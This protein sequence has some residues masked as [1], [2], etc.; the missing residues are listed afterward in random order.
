MKVCI[1]GTTRGIG[2][3]LAEHFKNKGCEV[4][5]LNRGDLKV[6]PGVG[7]DLYINNAYANGCQIDIFNQLYS[8]VAKMV[9]IG[10]IA[11]DYPDPDMPAYSQHKKELKER[12]LEIANSS[13]N[14]ADILLL[15]LTGES[16]NDSNLII[17][18]IEFWLANPKITC[19]SFVPGKPN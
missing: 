17:R 3:S 1:T 2:K 7:C 12:V 14:K 18:T 4:V 19:V 15:Q 8:S 16:Y 6:E 9:V 5:E 13:I 10:S 11:S